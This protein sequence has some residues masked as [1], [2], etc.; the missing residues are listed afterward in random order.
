MPNKMIDGNSNTYA[1]LFIEQ[2]VNTCAPNA[3]ESK[4]GPNFY[5]YELYKATP[6]KYRQNLAERRE[7]DK[8]IEEAL[9]DTT[10]K[11]KK[12]ETTTKN[13]L[14]LDIES[15]KKSNACPPTIQQ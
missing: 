15:H 3:P 10:E 5:L 8:I 6:N 13:L 11:I 9:Q 4:N 12:L 2:L 1:K 14:N 7:F